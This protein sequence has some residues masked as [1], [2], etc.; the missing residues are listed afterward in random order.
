MESA[1]E[2]E[3]QHTDRGNEM[4]RSSEKRMSMGRRKSQRTAAHAVA[5]I[6]A[7]H[8]AQCMHLAL[9]LTAIGVRVLVFLDPRLLCA[10][11][12][13]CGARFERACGVELTAHLQRLT[14]EQRPGS[15][16]LAN[17]TAMVT[18][19]RT[20]THTCETQ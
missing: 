9:P 2:N 3:A 17:A 6:N 10:D 8:P 15:D 5:E 11:L 13:Q 12:G 20:T 18:A 1:E 19:K 14:V 16:K 7:S 4:H